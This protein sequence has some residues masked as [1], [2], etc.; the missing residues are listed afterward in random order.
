[1]DLIL[2]EED[3]F[4]VIILAPAHTEYTEGIVIPNYNY[5]RTPLEMSKSIP[6]R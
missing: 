1:M 6:Q 5:F 3:I 2:R 4:K